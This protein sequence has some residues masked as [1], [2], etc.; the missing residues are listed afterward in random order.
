GFRGI[1][2]E[3]VRFAL[4]AMVAQKLRSFLTLLGI[5]AGVATVIA[6]V[7]FVSGFN[8]A[9]TDSFSAF[10]TTLVQFQK[11]EQRFGGGG[12]LPEDQKRRRNLTIEDAEALKRSSPLA[13]A[14]SQER[15]LFGPAGAALIIKTPEGTEANGPTFVGTNPDY[16]P[17][18]N[19]FVEDGRFLVEAD[20]AHA[21]RT[22]V[23]GPETAKALFGGKDPIG[24]TVL[25]NGNAFGVVGLLEKK[26]SFLGGDADNIMLIPISTFDEMFP[27]IKNGT[28]DTIHIATVPKDPKQ[29]YEMMDQE[30]AILRA[31]RGLRANQP[32]DFAI[33]TSEAQLKTFQQITGGIAGAMILIAAIALLVGGVGVMNIML[34]SVTERTR[35]IGVR[36]ALGATR[37]DIAM[38]FLVEAISLTG[39][40]GAVGIATGLGIAMLVRLVFEFPAAAPLWSIVLGFGVSTAVGLIFGLWPAL[41]AAKQDPIEA[42]RYE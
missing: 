35:E 4:R 19:S 3:N 1:G 28:G 31:R 7:S 27:Q 25:V 39:V 42:L 6:M 41:K 32:N 40:G 22:C 26:G 37:R 38:Q 24:R 36:K 9:V 16:A 13:A 5:V 18:N 10:G 21:S 34:V 17:A 14:V 12:P 23:L 29:M 30:V 15:Y 11:Y 2:T 33:F 8:A 20:I